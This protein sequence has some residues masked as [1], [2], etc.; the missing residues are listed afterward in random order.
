MQIL[1][2]LCEGDKSGPA[3]DAFAGLA[4]LTLAD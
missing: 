1:V 2:L 3:E 4:M